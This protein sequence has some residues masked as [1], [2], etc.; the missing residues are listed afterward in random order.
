[1]LKEQYLYNALI[2]DVYDGDTVTALVDLG[3]DVQFRCK[4]RLFGINAPELK[5]ETSEKGKEA[6][7]KLTELIGGKKVVVETVKD[8]KEKYGRYLAQIYVNQINVNTWM[9]NNG[10]AKEAFY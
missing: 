1:M 6:R 2:T 7:D 4:L 9:V 3:F 8:K 10:F 5:G